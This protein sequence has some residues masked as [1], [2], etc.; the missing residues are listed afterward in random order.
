VALKVEDTEE[1]GQVRGQRPRRT[2]PDHPDGN[3][4]REGYELAVSR[5]RGVIKEIDGV[6]ASRS[7]NW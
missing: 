6:A 2:A 1:D 5:P 4:R 7:S 3:M